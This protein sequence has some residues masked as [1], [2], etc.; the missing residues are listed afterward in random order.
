MR[1]TYVVL[2]IIMALIILVVTAL[3]APST[4]PYSPSNPYWDGYLS[5]VRI[6]GANITY[7]EIGNASTVILIPMVKPGNSFIARLKGFLNGGGTLVLL[8]NG[9]F[10]GNYILTK[11]NITE[12][13]ASTPV[14]DPVINYGNEHLP[15]AISTLPGINYVVLN[16]PTYILNAPSDSVVL[17]SSQFSSAGDVKG[18]LPIV[19]VVNYGHGKLILVADPAMFVNTML[20]L[21]DNEELLEWLCSRKPVVF[22]NGYVAKIS[23]ISI[24]REYLVL[25]YEYVRIAGVNYLLAIIPI[26]ITIMWFMRRGEYNEQ[27]R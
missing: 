10:F 5:A 13:F 12:R 6:C 15:I 18:P 23:P 24:I 9:M 25:S 17:W 14:I 3:Y 22:I 2:L 1:I 27:V 8:D 20:G 26:L 4:D 21:Y 19:A 11:L 16:D 7:Y